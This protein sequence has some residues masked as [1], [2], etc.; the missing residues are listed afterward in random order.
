MIFCLLLELLW[1]F[2]FL[3]LSGYSSYSAKSSCLEMG[4]RYLPSGI[5]ATPAPCSRGPKRLRTFQRHR[6]P[7]RPTWFCDLKLFRSETLSQSMT[8]F[9]K[10]Q[11]RIFSVVLHFLRLPFGWLWPKCFPTT[12][13]QDW[14]PKLCALYLSSHWLIAFRKS[15]YTVFAYF[16]NMRYR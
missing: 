8:L 1:H 13:S 5:D 16:G 4:L 7:G 9:P 12:F 11:K 2:L 14:D 3:N 10:P 15:G 6:C